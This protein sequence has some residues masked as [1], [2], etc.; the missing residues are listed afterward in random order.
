MVELAVPP[1]SRPESGALRDRPDRPQPHSVAPDPGTGPGMSVTVAGAIAGASTPSGT[2]AP[3]RWWLLGAA[4]EAGPP[5]G[6]I[7]GFV[8]SG[9]EQSRSG[10]RITRRHA[11]V[12]RSRGHQNRAAAVPPTVGSSK[13]RHPRGHLRDG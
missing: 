2:S 10:P 9:L 5:A 8:T 13:P 12:G 11:S 3:W 1:L 7:G 4:A 6:G